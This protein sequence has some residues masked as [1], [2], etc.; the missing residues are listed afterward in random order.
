MAFLL[1]YG[2][3]ANAQSQGL[4]SVVVPGHDHR[5]GA[6]TAVSVI[7]A[8][9]DTSLLRRKPPTARARAAPIAAHHPSAG[10]PTTT[11]PGTW[12]RGSYAGSGCC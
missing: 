11:R 5:A 9:V 7:A 8:L 1:A 10:G 12:S 4:C 6:L 3:C 2:A